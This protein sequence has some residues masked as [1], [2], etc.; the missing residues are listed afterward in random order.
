MLDMQVLIE[1]GL[2]ASGALLGPPAIGAAK[3][4]CLDAYYPGLPS[5]AGHGQQCT[6]NDVL[7]RACRCIEPPDPAPHG[8]TP[9]A[10]ET[11]QPRQTV[12]YPARIPAQPMSPLTKSRTFRDRNPD[13]PDRFSGDIF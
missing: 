4:K 3:Q 12:A 2:R 1:F 9:H 8:L 5:G 13:I 11:Q 6:W 7:Q 10:A